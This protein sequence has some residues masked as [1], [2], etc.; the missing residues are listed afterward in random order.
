MY[1]ATPDP[2]CYPGTSVLKN[3]PGIRNQ[4]ELD[5]FETAITA[6][7]VPSYARAPAPCPQP[8]AARIS[9][10]ARRLPQRGHI[11]RPFS[12]ASGMLRPRV[13]TRVSKLSWYRHLAFERV[14]STS[15]PKQRA[16]TRH[17]ADKASSECAKGQPLAKRP[18]FLCNNS[19][20][21]TVCDT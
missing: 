4:A 13:H 10:L 8:I 14:Y 18:T 12:P 11:M 9:G 16:C 19:I 1:D 2:Y 3:I 21:G 20:L 5:R 15:P 7:K 6:K 17:P